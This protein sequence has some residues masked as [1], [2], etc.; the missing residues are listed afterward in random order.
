MLDVL[1]SP[2]AA[3]RTGWMP[4]VGIVVGIWL[5]I[6]LVIRWLNRRDRRRREVEAQL[7]EMEHQIWLESLPEEQRTAVEAAAQQRREIAREARR[8]LGLPEEEA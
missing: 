7:R 8:R 5:G 2:Q 4:M 6:W 1:Q 3:A